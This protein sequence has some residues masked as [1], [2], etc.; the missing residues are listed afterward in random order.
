MSRAFRIACCLLLRFYPTSYRARW[1]AELES[2]ILACVARE[3]RRIGEPGIVY[4]WVLLVFAH[5]GQERRSGLKNC[6]S[7]S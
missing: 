3:R 4:A 6:D 1:R 7:G 2:A 5:C